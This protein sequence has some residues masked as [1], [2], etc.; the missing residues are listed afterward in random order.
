M[1]PDKP[2]HKTFCTGTIWST[3]KEGECVQVNKEDFCRKVGTTNV[4]IHQYKMVW[5]EKANACELTPTGVSDT[6]KNVP[7]V[8]G[9]ACD[10]W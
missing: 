7:N 8:T 5:D 2:Q 3:A 4:D 10:V 6:V 9:R 1:D